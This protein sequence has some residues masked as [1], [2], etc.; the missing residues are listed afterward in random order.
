MSDAGLLCQTCSA[1]ASLPHRGNA[2]LPMN[3]QPDRLSLRLLLFFLLLH[4]IN[5][6]GHA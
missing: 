2:W 5:Q 1:S 4:V 6:R 3:V